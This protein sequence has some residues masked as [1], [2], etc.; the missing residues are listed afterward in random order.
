MRQFRLLLTVAVLG[1]AG[2]TDS[3]GITS[4][5]DIESNLGGLWIQSTSSVG[6]GSIYLVVNG[7]TV[8][9]VGTLTAEANRGGTVRVSGVIEGSQIKLDLAED[10]GTTLHYS[11]QMMSNLLISGEYVGHGDPVAANYQKPTGVLSAAR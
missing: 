4:P 1:V 3:L 5:R 6:A 9:G 10:N 11:E 8:N 2:C 7:T